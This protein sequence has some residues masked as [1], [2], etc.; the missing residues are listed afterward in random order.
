MLTP[1]DLVYRIQAANIRMIITMAEHADK[2]EE[3]RDECPT[4]RVRLMIDGMRDG[5]A[6]TR[7]ARLPRALLAQTGQP[8]RHAP[9]EI[10]R[11]AA[12]LLHLR[13]HRRAED[14]GPRPLLPARAPRHRARVARPA[15]KRSPPDDLGYRLG[16]GGMGQNIRPVDR[17]CLHFVYDITGS[18]THQ[19]CRSWRS[20][21]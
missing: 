5:W 16:Q 3:I 6:V 2:V 12:D 17:W 18:S 13:H 7:R 19:I 14:G 20:M 9:D 15:R 1:K 21:A 11:P 4:L 10:D 8:P